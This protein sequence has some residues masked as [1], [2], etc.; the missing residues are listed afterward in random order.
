MGQINSAIHELHRMDAMAEQDNWLTG[1][2]PLAK[3]LV[4]IIYVGTVTSFHKYDLN[5]VLGMTIY[6]VI[7]IVLAQISLKHMVSRLRGVLVVVVLVGIV[8]PFLDRD[9]LLSFGGIMVSGGVISMLTLMCKG[10]FSL[11]AAYILMVSTSMEEICYAL[12]KAHVPKLLVTVIMLIYRYIIVFLKEGERISQAYTLRAPGQ[13]GIH[14][15]V[16]GTL[17]GQMLLRSVDRAQNVY[18]S[19]QLR[20]FNGE[21][22][23]AAR[24]NYHPASVLYGVV[25]CAIFIILRYV[26]LFSL[27]GQFI[28]G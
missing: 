3:L 11:V 5:G 24:E 4:T 28:S 27:V 8:N 7:L 22:A 9:I 14:Y 18:E 13:R 17:L 19:M 12:C 25:W 15:K 21:Y 26:P 16:W 2:H 10:I 1:M 6:L 23:F 20:G